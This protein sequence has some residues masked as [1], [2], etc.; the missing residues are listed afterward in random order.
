MNE[1]QFSER[2]IQAISLGMVEV[3][4]EG[5]Q[6]RIIAPPLADQLTDEEWL[7]II[8]AAGEV[9]KELESLGYKVNY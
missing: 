8:Q 5:K 6:A 7:N 2:L 9:G 4:E 3:D 1:S